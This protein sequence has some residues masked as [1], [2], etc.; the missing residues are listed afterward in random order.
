METTIE[1]ATRNAYSLYKSLRAARDE[2]RQQD[3]A[4]D[5]RKAI[6]QAYIDY[7]AKFEALVMEQAKAVER[8]THLRAMMAAPDPVER[9]NWARALQQ[10]RDQLARIEGKIEVME[11]FLNT[12]NTL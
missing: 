4:A 3:P 10:T 7:G 6:K 5:L 9:D 2:A 1:K 12:L 8:A 11:Q